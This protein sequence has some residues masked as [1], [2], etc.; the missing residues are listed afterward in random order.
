MTPAQFVEMYCAANKCRPSDRSRRIQFEPM[1]PFVLGGGRSEGERFHIT[2]V[3]E[4]GGRIQIV[5]SYGGL[6]HFLEREGD[7]SFS[8]QAQAHFVRWGEM[9]R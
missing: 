2:T 4:E 1:P 3:W 8:A 5:V 6:R 9:I 7:A